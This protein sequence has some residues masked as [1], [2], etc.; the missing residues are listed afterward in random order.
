MYNNIDLK[1]QSVLIQIT[2]R[3]KHLQ[4]R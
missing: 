1:E 3:R 2:A 4:L